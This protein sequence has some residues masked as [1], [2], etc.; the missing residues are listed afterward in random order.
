MFVEESLEGFLKTLKEHPGVIILLNYKKIDE[1]KNHAQK[2][3]N[4]YIFPDLNKITV[5]FPIMSDSFIGNKLINQF[6]C[7]NY[8]SYIFCK[9]QTQKLIKVN[10]KMEGVFN[11]NLFIDNVLKGLP[12]T[13]A[14]LKASLKKSLKVSIIH[15]YNNDIKNDD[16]NSSEEIDKLF[17]NLGKIEFNDNNNNNSNNKKINVQDST[18]GLTDGQVIAKREQQMKELEKQEEEKI[19]KEEEEKQKIKDEENKIK[20][21]NEDYQKNAEL[22]K[23]LL[24]EE[25]NEDNPNVSTIILR[26][27]DGDK[28]IERRFLKTDKINVLYLFVKSKGREIFFEQESNDFDLIFGFPPKNLDNSKNNT[29]E[30]EGLF[31]NAIIHIR[32][33]E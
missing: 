21:R 30:D 27:P 13:N 24:P 12:D 31:P 29:L 33:K 3:N 4:N 10:G 32:E 11:I 7:Y 18:F 9:Y 1:F 17:E 25:P 26:Y 16:F 5:L 20:K 22:S 28:T 15:N 8:P 6:S 14:K 2:I 23:K 19:R